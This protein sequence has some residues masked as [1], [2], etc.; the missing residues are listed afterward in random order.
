MPPAR[1]LDPAFGV[2]FEEFQADLSKQ[3]DRIRIY[4]F[5]NVG[6][7]PSAVEAVRPSARQ[8]PTMTP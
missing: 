3:M 7:Q 2:G 4:G 5:K 1:F 8:G 6:G